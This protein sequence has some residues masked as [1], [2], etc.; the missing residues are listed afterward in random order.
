MSERKSLNFSAE[1]AAIYEEFIYHINSVDYAAGVDGSLMT[2]FNSS[3]RKYLQSAEIDLNRRGGW[4]YTK[5]PEHMNVKKGGKFMIVNKVLDLGTFYEW[6]RKYEDLRFELQ[7]NMLAD[8][9]LA[10]YETAENL[11]QKG[12]ANLLFLGRDGLSPLEGTEPIIPEHFEQ[13]IDRYMSDP[14]DYLRANHRLLYEKG[15][16]TVQEI[17]EK[18]DKIQAEL[19][20]YLSNAKEAYK[21]DKIAKFTQQLD[22]LEDV[23]PYVDE[24]GATLTE[25]NIDNHIKEY[26]SYGYYYTAGFPKTDE[27]KK[28]KHTFTIPK[29]AFA[30]SDKS[31]DEMVDYDVREV[32]ITDE[33]LIPILNLTVDKTFTVF[34]P[35]RQA[36]QHFETLNARHPQ[37][38]SE[39]WSEYIKSNG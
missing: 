21:K 1:T 14:I 8:A 10:D 6:Q 24:I 26:K 4:S 16:V 27:H 20:K 37:H 36:V 25:L 5:S 39:I 23:L 3:S 28:K 34:L 17:R 7:G 22:Q 19:A 11:G 35:Y 29:V 33:S 12:A 31:K 15:I 38:I 13:A 2:D 32:E 9:K 18:A 30:F